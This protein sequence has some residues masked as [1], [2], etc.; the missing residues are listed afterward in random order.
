[1]KN[2]IIIVSNNDD[3]NISKHRRPK[4]NFRSWYHPVMSVEKS[5]I[6]SSLMYPSKTQRFLRRLSYKCNKPTSPY[7]TEPPP[8]MSFIDFES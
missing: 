3:N 4:P 2:K 8:A 6:S 7:R 1:M 5:R